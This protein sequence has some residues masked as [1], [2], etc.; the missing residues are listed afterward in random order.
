M[1][2]R[3]RNKNINILFVGASNTGKS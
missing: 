1:K 3:K 2:Y